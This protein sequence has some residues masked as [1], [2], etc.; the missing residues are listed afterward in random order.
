M[1]RTAAKPPQERWNSVGEYVHN[2]L[3]Q[4]DQHRVLQEMGMA[5]SGEFVQVGTKSGEQIKWL[6]RIVVIASGDTDRYC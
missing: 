1:V 4:G 5:L 2:N 6:H 3:R